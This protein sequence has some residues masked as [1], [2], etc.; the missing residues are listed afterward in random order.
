MFGFI[1][2]MFIAKMGCF[3]LNSYN[4]LNVVVAAMT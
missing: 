1:E 4:V 2:K 3:E